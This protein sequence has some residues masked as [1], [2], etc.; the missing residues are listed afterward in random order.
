MWWKVGICSALL[1]I[2]A[3]PSVL[4]E[5]VPSV[6]TANKFLSAE[7]Q[8]IIDTKTDEMLVE[9]KNYQ[10]E[11]FQ[12]FDMRMQTLV[13]DMKI[14]VII[15][16]LGVILLGMGVTSYLMLK[17]FKRY[18]YE[19]FLEEQLKKGG[20]VAQEGQYDMNG[21]EQMQETDWYPQQPQQTLGMEMGQ[22]WASD[23]TQMNQWQAQPAYDGAWQAPL[24]TVPQYKEEWMEQNYPVQQQEDPMQ[25]PG[26]QPEY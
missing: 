25:S 24:E 21:V 11:N 13:D 14:K 10:D 23:M 19:E 5:E 20:Q 9:M 4:A 1:V 12:I 2:L 15:G 8:R 16:G 17:Y 7:T 6:D 3:L 18:S 26:W 22:G